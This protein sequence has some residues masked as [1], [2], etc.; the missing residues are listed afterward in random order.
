MDAAKHDQNRVPVVQFSW[1]HQ[2]L[3]SPVVISGNSV[4]PASVVL[5]LGVWIDRGLSMS[6]HV[7]PRSS[8]VVLLYCISFTASVVQSAMSRSSHW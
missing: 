2:L 8:Q 6:T 3:A 4:D 1:I 5:G 7:T